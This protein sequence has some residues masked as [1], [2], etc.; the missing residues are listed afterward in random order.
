MS[1]DGFQHKPGG[2]ATLVLFI[3]TLVTRKHAPPC[4]GTVQLIKSHQIWNNDEIFMY[5]ETGLSLHPTI[6]QV[7]FLCLQSFLA[8]TLCKMQL[9]TSDW[10][11]IVLM[12]AMCY[13]AMCFNPIKSCTTSGNV[14]Q[15]FVLKKLILQFTDAKLITVLLEQH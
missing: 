15:Q 13:T 1:S 10:R 8:L 6:A 4:W 3:G 2:L 9:L 11:F 5:S 14:T 12:K 7:Q